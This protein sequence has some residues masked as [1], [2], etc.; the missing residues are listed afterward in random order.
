[1]GLSFPGYETS[2][3]AAWTSRLLVLLEDGADI[4]AIDKVGGMTAHAVWLKAEAMGATATRPRSR[5]QPLRPRR[6]HRA[7]LGGPWA[8][9]LIWL[10]EVLLDRGAEIDCQVNGWTPT[11]A[12]WRAENGTELGARI[13]VQRG[14]D[15][16]ARDVHGRSVLHWFTIQGC[17]ETV[18]L[19][20]R[21]AESGGPR[22]GRPS[23][24]RM[25]TDSRPRLLPSSQATGKLPMCSERRLT[26]TEAAAI[27]H[28]THFIGRNLGSGSVLTLN[29]TMYRPKMVSALLAYA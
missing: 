11:L 22:S 18:P 2:S 7:A 29:P 6:P 26:T 4:D 10:V 23:R 1:M 3:T 12:G 14:A 5:R 16:N 15:V 17:G 25:P 13:L 8:H 27:P 20:L 19:L 21:S 9:M 28:R 24:G